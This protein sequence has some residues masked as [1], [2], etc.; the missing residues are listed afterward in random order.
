MT[1]NLKA[2]YSA[3]PTIEVEVQPL[4]EKDNPVGE[5]Y[6]ISSKDGVIDLGHSVLTTWEFLLRVQAENEHRPERG[7]AI[8]SSFS[9]PEWGSGRPWPNA[10]VTYFFDHGT[11]DEEERSWMVGAMQ[12]MTAGTGISFRR[13]DDNTWNR[14]WHWLGFSGYLYIN[15]QDLGNSTTTGDPITGMASLG[16][17]GC[18]FLRMDDD[19]MRD[20]R[21]DY[22]NHEMGHVFGLLHEHQ[23]YDRDDYVRVVPTDT[24]HRKMTESR[25]YCRILWIFDCRTV[26]NTT[27][28][29]TPYDF[30]SVM[31][32]PS[33]AEVITLRN[34]G[35]WYDWHQNMHLWG[36]DNGMTWFSLWDI[37]TIKRLY[38]ISPNPE[39]TDDPVAVPYHR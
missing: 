12:R 21:E 29:S 27:H 8:T 1:E 22:F 34:G 11:L 24:D 7:F 16:K 31:H 5:P 3:I 25:R 2:E 37:Y 19:S 35:I 9:D 36:E 26:S 18:S 4:D 38:G 33:Q 30:Q 39:P 17:M 14:F 20:R 6:I 15:E 28:Y 10:T 32:Y 13:V 23:R